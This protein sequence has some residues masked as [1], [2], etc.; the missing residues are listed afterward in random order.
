LPTGNFL[1]RFDAE[2]DAEPELSSSKDLGMDCYDWKACDRLRF[3]VT[4]ASR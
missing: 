3:I 4:G 1:E 2:P